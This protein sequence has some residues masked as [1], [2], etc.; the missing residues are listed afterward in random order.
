MKNKILFE[1]FS[2]NKEIELKNRIAMAPMTRCMADKSLVPTQQSAD[3]YGRRADAGLIITEA[4]IIRPDGQGYPNTPGIFSEEQVKGWQKVTK[5]VHQKDG[6]IFLQLWHCGRV[7]HPHFF[8]GGHIIAPSAEKL[9]GTVPRMRDLKYQEPKPATQAEISQL[10]ADFTKAATNAIE[11]GFDG[12]EI[13]GA[14]GYLLDQF[15]HYNTNKREDEYGGSPE[16]MARF[17]LEIIDSITDKIG[18][19]RTALRLSPGAY[20][21]LEGDTRDRQVFEHLLTKLNSFDLA[22]LHLGL[23]DESMKFDYLDGNATDFVRKHYLKTLMGVGGYTADTGSK[24][25]SLNRFD[26]LA[27][28]R[29]FIANPDYITKIKNNE[30]LIEY[31]ESMLNELI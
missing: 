29:P 7:A 18:N 5:K 24:A 26:L 2:L 4:T 30:P 17:P 9:E 12:V 28:G 15:L 20:F 1:S 19:E 11:A 10:V 14:N 21:L 13:H 23:F 25:I 31:K 16:N 6:K 3:Y 8:K 27:I 22:Y